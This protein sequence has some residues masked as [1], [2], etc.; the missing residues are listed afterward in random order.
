MQIDLF[1]ETRSDYLCKCQHK[2]I[3]PA[4]LFDIKQVSYNI[5]INIV[6]EFHYLKRQA[7]C[8]SAFGL[9]CKTC[10]MICGI[11]IYGTPSSSSLREGICGKEEKDNVIELT[12]LWIKDG[13]PT[14][15]E[16]YLIGNT[17]KKSGKE[18]IV[19]YAE[20]DQGHIGIVYQATNWIYTGLSEKRTNWKIEGIQKHSQTIADKYS[21]LEAKIKYGDKFSIIERPRKHRYVYFNCKP[22]RKKQLISKLNYSISPYPKKIVQDGIQGI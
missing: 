1:G 16:S 15:T 22:N 5:A 9:Y 19:S 10:K 18:I 11:I 20:P 8:S 6:C 7:P 21:S 3:S 14:N 2:Q 12:R 17:L 4:N 13:T